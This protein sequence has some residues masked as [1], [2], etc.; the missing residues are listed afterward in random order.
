MGNTANQYLTI[1]MDVGEKLLQYGAETNRTEDSI[2]RICI[3]YG[4]TRVDVFSITVNIETTMHI[5][6]DTYTQTRR[7][8][9][10]TMDIDKLSALNEL[11]RYICKNKPPLVVVEKRLN[12]IEE[13]QNYPYSLQVFAY[14]LISGSFC[15]FFGG[16]FHD[17]IAAAIIGALLKPIES[18]IKKYS[19]N[20]IFIPLVW[21]LCG[22]LLNAF[23][24]HIG[25]GD[26]YDLIAIG[27]IM[28]LIPGT[29]F[30]NALRDLFIGDS[31]T[32]VIHIV[33]AILVAISIA[34]GFVCIHSFLL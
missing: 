10:T 11:S 14:A 13:I 16:N 32:G 20:R 34:L 17:M 31:I 28:I 6:Y 1:A 7:I 15:V 27:N 4:A 19:N 33:E 30:T 24:L 23:F 25:I 12:N 22:G 26:H 18:G 29:A 9:N 21:S 3:A 2:R 8:Q 5:G